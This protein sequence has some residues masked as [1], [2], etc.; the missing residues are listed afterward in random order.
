MAELIAGIDQ[1][2]SPGKLPPV[3]A[4]YILDYLQIW[5]T[6]R[7]LYSINIILNINKIKID[8]FNNTWKYSEIVIG[9]ATGFSVSC[10]VMSVEGVRGGLK[11]IHSEENP[12]LDPA[13][14]ND[15]GLERCVRRWE[16]G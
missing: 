11:S 3:H 9:S 1:M 6:S 5:T 13:D 14:E 4:A 15:G 8:I 7:Q 16:C 10:G 12:P 2:V